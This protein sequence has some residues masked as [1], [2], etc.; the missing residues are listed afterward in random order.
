MVAIPADQSAQVQAALQEIVTEYGRS[1]LTNSGQ[2]SNLLK[3]LLPDAPGVARMLVAAAEDR[4]ADELRDHAEG[5]LDG[6]TAAR[7][8]TSSFAGRTMFA[9]EACALVVGEIARALGIVHEVAY[10]PTVVSQPDGPARLASQPGDGQASWPS[11][12]QPRLALSSGDIDFG[13]VAQHGPF[14]ER[15]ISIG[16]AG[17]GSLNASVATSANW[18]ILRQS[19]DDLIISADTRVIGEHEGVV[20]VE[21]DGGSAAIRIRAAVR[22]GPQSSDGHAPPAGSSPGAVNLRVV[23]DQPAR[24]EQPA[25]AEHWPWPWTANPNRRPRNK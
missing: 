4:V 25:E 2:M 1:A 18:I 23:A 11:E 5:G 21:S 19:G 15:H 14:P 24:H 16:N 10:S 17:G 7:L 12:E 8:V 9:P 20:T 13:Q 22:S 6:A 3:D